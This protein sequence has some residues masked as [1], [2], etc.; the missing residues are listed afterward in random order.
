MITPNVVNKMVT[1][2][3]ICNTNGVIPEYFFF[4]FF[5]RFSA[6][7][8][9]YTFSARRGSHVLVPNGKMSKNWQDK[10][11]WVNQEG[12]G[13]RYCRAINFS[14]TIPKLFS[15]NQVVP[16]EFP[17]YVLSGAGMSPS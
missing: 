16:D 1:F 4:K 6:I 10:W 15:Y 9:K 3:M 11:L 17:E 12:V 7:R 2:E 13:Q 8:D 14:K 5:F